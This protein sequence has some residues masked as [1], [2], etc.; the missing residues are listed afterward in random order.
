[1]NGNGDLKFVQTIREREKTTSVTLHSSYGIC[2]HNRNGEIS[3][4][5]WRSFLCWLPVRVDSPWQTIAIQRGTG[6]N[7]TDNGWKTT[8]QT[9]D[10]PNSTNEHGIGK[11]RTLTL[12]L[13][14][15]LAV[16]LCKRLSKK[17]L[18]CLSDRLSAEGENIDRKIS[19]T[20]FVNVF[21]CMCVLA[22]ILPTKV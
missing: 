17:H 16:H 7:N 1:M 12:S 3:Y 20:L 5:P 22:L 10:A 13:C 18:V 15:M 8:T 9:S 4:F 2:Q 11:N 21:V 14:L 19:L 6:N